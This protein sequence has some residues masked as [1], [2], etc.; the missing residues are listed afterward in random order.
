[1]SYN[2]THDDI[3]CDELRLSRIFMNIVSNSIKYTKSGGFVTFSIDEEKNEDSSSKYI[4]TVKDNGIGMS[5]EYLKH[6]FE[7]FTREQTATTS[8]IQGTG[9]G[10]S[11]TKSLV[12]LMNGDISVESELGKGTTVK[13]SIDFKYAVEVTEEFSYEDSKKSSGNLKGRRVLLVE[14]NDLNREIA[15]DTL[16]EEGLIVEE[17]CDGTEAVE[18][19]RSLEDAHYYDMIL[20][21]I[22]M[23]TMDGYT[24]TREIRSLKE[25][26]NADIV[27]IVAMTANAFEEDKQKAFD[28]GMND[29]LA[30]P[31]DIPILKST[32]QKF[33]K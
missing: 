15:K 11:I 27:P 21:D 3:M 29:H 22:Q 30:K 4:F 17:A 26:P 10:M 12:D 24:A 31:I 5:D 32:L 9:L 2:C 1:M 14:D 23:P 33:I 16:E 8:G 20:M 7:S 28:C 19:V 18:M 25:V 6:I 13:V